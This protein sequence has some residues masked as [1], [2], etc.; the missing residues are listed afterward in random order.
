M[1]VHSKI[2]SHS[3]FDWSC[4]VNNIGDP[5]TEQ[6]MSEVKAIAVHLPQFSGNQTLTWVRRANQHF[7]Q[8]DLTNSTT[9]VDYTLKSAPESVFQTIAPW[10]VTQPVDNT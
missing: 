9:R 5:A 6:K 1:L 7:K 8:Y 3:G 10:L 4:C 2:R